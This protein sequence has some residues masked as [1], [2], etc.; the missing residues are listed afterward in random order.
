MIQ[1]ISQYMTKN[2]HMNKVVDLITLIRT[3]A[4]S[5]SKQIMKRTKITII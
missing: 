5:L 4:Y 1:S 3:Q 2:K